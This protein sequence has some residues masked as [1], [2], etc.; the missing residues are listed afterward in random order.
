MF[1]NITD[2]PRLFSFSDAVKKYEGTKGIRGRTHVKPL[3]SS[4]RDPDTYK[5]TAKRDQ[6]GEIVAVQCWLYNTPVLVYWKDRLEVNGYNTQTTNKFIEGIAPHWLRAYQRS[7]CQV[8]FIRNEGEFLAGEGGKVVVP[9]GEDYFPM[10]GGVVA[11]KLNQVVLNRTRAATARKQ[12]KD[13]VKL[14]TLT[15]KID[16]YWDAMVSSDEIA[17]NEETAWLKGLLK[18]GQY[19]RTIRRNWHRDGTWGELPSF[20]GFG[21]W[22]RDSQ[23]QLLPHLKK[24]LYNAQYEQDGCYDKFPAEYGTIPKEWEVV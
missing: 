3:K 5:I 16:G 17:P 22:G 12:C 11:A 13:V 23:E 8:F 7:N 15:S 6:D 20:A 21:T 19:R 10:S 24:F 18:N 1:G 2:L 14:A 4:R 9:V